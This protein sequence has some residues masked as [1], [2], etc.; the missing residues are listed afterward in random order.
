MSLD[1]YDLYAKLW[2]MIVKNGQK[3]TFEKNLKACQTDYEIITFCRRELEKSGLL[4]DLMPHVDDCKDETLAIAHRKE[5]NQYFHPR[6]KRYTDACE[7]YNQS[8]AVSPVG[9]ESMGIAYANRSAVCFELREYEDCLLNIRLAMENNYPKH[10]IPKLEK[11]MAECLKLASKTPN[12][13]KA[14]DRQ[15]PK[16]SYKSNPKIPHISSC[17]ELKEDPQFGRYLVTNRD[18]KAGDIL[19]MEEPFSSIL[20]TDLKY[21]TC[22]FC[23]EDLFLRLIP[24]E[25]CTVTMFCSNACKDKAYQAYHRIECPIVKEART[26]VTKVIFMAFRTTTTAIS[27]FDNNFDELKSHV[28]NID[29]TTLNPFQFDWNTITARERYSTIHALATNKNL[30]TPSDLLQRSIYAI[31]L[32][33]ALFN[34][35][36]LK[37]ICDGTESHRDFVRVLIFHHSQTSPVNMHSTMYINYRPNTA[38]VHAHDN[39]GCGAF[40]ILSMINH[41]CSP[42]MVRITLPDGRNMAFLNRPLKKGDQIFDNYGFHHC[43]DTFKERQSGLEQQYCFKC[44]CEACE[45]DYPLFNELP[46][47]IILKLSDQPI[48]PRELDLLSRHDLETAREKVPTYCRFLNNYDDQYPQFLISSV[49]EA[50]L[51]CFHIIFAKQSHKLKYKDLCEF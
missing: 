9:S 44:Q 36:W 8:I 31:V 46:Q 7:F 34:K 48:S 4:K 22:D 43:L 2:V 5:G 26:L 16:L 39:L 30:R 21:S 47:L 33:D 11:R 23:H 3:E 40:P 12:V 15:Q 28:Q 14:N 13:K 20:L 49:Q 19:I 37:D 38:D 1:A 18:V 6:I 29:E 51:R 41:S 42:N 10:L 17:L 24:C 35:T 45:K 32:S 25:G 27:T 50:L